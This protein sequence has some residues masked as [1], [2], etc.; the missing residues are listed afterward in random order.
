MKRILKGFKP[1]LPSFILVCLFVFGRTMADLQLPKLMADIVNNGIAA[2]DNS[3]ILRI[4]GEMLLVSLFGMACAIGTSYLSSQNAMGFSRDLRNQT[5]TKIENFGQSEFDKFGTASLITRSTNDVRQMQMLL[6]MG[7]RMMLAAPIMFIGGIINVVRTNLS[8]ST[9]LI[10]SLPAV[11]LSVTMIAGRA[12]PMFD[13]MQKRLDRLNLVMREGLSGVRVVRAFIRDDYQQE[14]F[15]KANEDLTDNAIKVNRLLAL[16]SPVMT[17]IMNL[18]IIATMW[19]GSLFI[20]KG[21]LMIGD[22]MAFIQYIGMIL[23]SLMGL[24]MIFIMYPR[25]AVSADRINEII[26]TEIT[27]QQPAGDKIIPFPQNDEVVV[28][29]DHV[30]FRYPG[31]EAPVLHDISFTASPGQTV[32][33]IGGTGSGKSTLAQLLLRFYDMESGSITMNGVDIRNL[34]LSKLRDRIGF[35]S[36]KTLL[37]TGSIADN[38]RFGKEDASDEEVLE[39]LE[40]AQAAKF[41]QEMPDGVKSTVSQ[42]GTN[43]SGGQKQRLS[44]ARALVRKP[45]VFVFDDS[46]SALD[47]RTDANLRKAMKSIT[48]RATV[49]IIAQRVSTIMNSD[50]IIVMN[51]GLIVGQG[52]HEELLAN[53]KVYQEI[54]ESQLSVEEY[55]VKALGGEAGAQNE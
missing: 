31:S 8:L 1:Y 39:A 55:S 54:L 17:I 49:I 23:G 11:I 53:C 22:L 38:I 7:Q 18:T 52:T 15:N 37:F 28:A 43:F 34:D 26:D 4:G 46:F 3:Y 32:A 35:V 30:T 6:M 36:Q 33:I 21:S 40:I 2:G 29:F 45:P 51:D 41:V 48:S 42:G 16:Q 50:L 12:T 27:V 44:I 47:F 19:F 24:S 20:N 10:F 14:R 25:A 5:F 9:I 13:I